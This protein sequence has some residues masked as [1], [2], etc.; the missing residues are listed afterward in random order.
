MKAKIIITTLVLIGSL[1]MYLWGIYD[2]TIGKIGW[3]IF[4]ITLNTITF[5]MCIINL[6]NF[7][8]NN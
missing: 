5:T 1:L 8:L 7:K 3:G 2:I 4:H 6:Y